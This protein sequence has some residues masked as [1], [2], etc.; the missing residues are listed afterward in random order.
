VSYE[1]LA[2][3][4]AHNYAASISVSLGDLRLVFKHIRL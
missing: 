4:Y 2:N 1:Y 3:W